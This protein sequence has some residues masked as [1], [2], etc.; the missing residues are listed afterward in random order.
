MEVEGCGEESS[1]LL[2]GFEL[3]LM[4]N[5]LCLPTSLFEGLL[6]YGMCIRVGESIYSDRIPLAA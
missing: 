2:L 6:L 5:T 4:Y 1:G 3:G